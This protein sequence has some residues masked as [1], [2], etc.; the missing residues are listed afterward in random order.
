MGLLKWLD[1]LIV[2]RREDIENKYRH[3]MDFIE[4]NLDKTGAEMLI[5]RFLNTLYEVRQ[6]ML[7]GLFLKDTNIPTEKYNKEEC[8][9]SNWEMLDG[10]NMKKLSMRDAVYKEILDSYILKY[11]TEKTIV[12]ETIFITGLIM[13]H[14]GIG[15][16]H[17]LDK[18]VK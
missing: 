11:T 1:S 8:I 4:A 16:A 17:I 15:N 12:K 9:Y 18:W 2:P 7:V 10:D 6:D 3:I 13:E 5:I 14:Y